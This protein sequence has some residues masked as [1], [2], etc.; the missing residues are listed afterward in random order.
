MV[1]MTKQLERQV[2]LVSKQLGRVEAQL[3]GYPVKDKHWRRLMELRRSYIK[4]LRDLG[5][6]YE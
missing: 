2:A 5:V 3:Q 4:Q 6:T 1:V